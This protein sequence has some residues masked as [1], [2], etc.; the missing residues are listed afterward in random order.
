MAH[1]ITDV[2]AGAVL[3]MGIAFGSVLFLNDYKK[4]RSPKGK[5]LN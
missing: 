1:W 2:M 4:S 3:G 5:R